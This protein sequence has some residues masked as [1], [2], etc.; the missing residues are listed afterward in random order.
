MGARPGRRKHLR[1]GRGDFHPRADA[2][3]GDGMVDTRLVATGL[4]ATGLVA[5]GLVATGLV[6][7][8]LVATGLVATGLVATGLVDWRSAGPKYCGGRPVPDGPAALSRSS[9]RRRCM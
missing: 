5:T 8:G 9:S 6:A 3:N 1:S 7:T 4:V 2:A